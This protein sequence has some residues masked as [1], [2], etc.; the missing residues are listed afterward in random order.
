MIEDVKIIPSLCLSNEIKYHLTPPIYKIANLQMRFYFT[1]HSQSHIQHT[2]PQ[3]HSCHSSPV[4][5]SGCPKP[6]V[7]AVLFGN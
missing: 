6:V 3:N 2:L 7:V 5:Q 1:L 4:P